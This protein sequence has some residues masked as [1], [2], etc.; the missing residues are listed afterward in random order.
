MKELDG[1]LVLMTERLL[2]RR[3]VPDDREPLLRIYG[4][5]EA[6]RWVADGVPLTQ[7]QAANWLEVTANNYRQRGYGMYTVTLRNGGSVIGFCGLVHPDDQDKPEVKYAFARE[8]WGHGYASEVVCA[9]LPYAAEKLGLKQIIA[10]VA[11]DNAASRRVLSK[12][13]MTLI[14]TLPE[15][16]GS[17]T[18]LLSWHAP[19]VALQ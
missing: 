12:A 17:Q 16:D 11:P 13:G 1:T 8:H 2:V 15:D 5:A 6:M 7:Q 19:A 10:T 18:L 14:D 4:D 3:W 9:L